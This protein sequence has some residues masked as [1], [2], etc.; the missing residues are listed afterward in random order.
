M[1]KTFSEL[2]RKARKTQNWTQKELA[3]RINVSRATISNWENGVAEPDYNTIC[4]LS[5]VLQC[6]FMP[7]R[8]ANGDD[9]HAKER[10]LRVIITENPVITVKSPGNAV[11]FTVGTVDFRLNGSDSHGNTIDFCISAGISVISDDN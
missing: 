5:E 4:R 7:Q 8:A 9:S 1:M 6:D 2:L 11:D 10:K 3:E